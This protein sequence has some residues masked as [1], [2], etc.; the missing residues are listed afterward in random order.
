[1][2]PIPEAARSLCRITP[3]VQTSTLGCYL[4]L[5]SMQRTAS[6]MLRGAAVKLSRLAA[7]DRT[8]GVVAAS[9]GNH[10]LGLSCAGRTF[11]IPVRIVVPDNAPRCK[12]E[13]ISGFG[14]EL[15]RHGSG[16]VEAEKM[17]RRLAALRDA[18]YVSAAE[19]AEVIEGNG[20]WLGRE[21][22]EQLPGLRRV[23]V[24]MGDGGLAAGLA[25]ELCAEGIEIIGVQPEVHPAMV[26]SLRQNRALTEF[27]G[28][29]T[30][31]EELEGGVGWRSFGVVRRLVP[32]IAQVSEI[33]VIEAVAFAFQ[34]LGLVME[35]SAATVVAAVC[36]GKVQVDEHTVL[37][38]T[39]GNIDGEF[40]QRC[41]SAARRLPAESSLSMSRAAGR[42]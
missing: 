38:I 11:G 6:C 4:K 20:G 35:A 28:Q 5:E 42:G 33:E 41:L 18:L 37:V 3:L 22:F 7:V 34:R 30:I 29:R 36:A 31:C 12:R 32:Q 19:D 27:Q 9:P 14:G 13:G 26:E 39:G 25:N 17:G 23:V 15:I 1:M 10:G 24:P 21:L 16:L 2:L 40:L 8:A